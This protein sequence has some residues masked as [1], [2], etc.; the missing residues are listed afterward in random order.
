LTALTSPTGIP[1]AA[2]LVTR[3]F[4]IAIRKKKFFQEK[5][6][7]AIGPL[8]LIALLFTTLIIFAAQGK[9]VRRFLHLFCF[10]SLADRPV[11][12][13]LNRSTLLAP[14]ASLHG[15]KQVVRS[16]TDVLRVVPPL[17]VY[18]LILFFG[19]LYACKRSKVSYGRTATQAFTGA[20]NNF[21]LAIAV[22]VATYGAGASF[23]LSRLLSPHP[24]SIRRF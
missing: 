21:E 12:C 24:S 9:Q 11:P 1:L 8:S 3:G 23:F 10:V 17:L 14:P 4:F 2:A 5:F 7:P 15:R 19:L 20:S 22:A 6:L 16:I 13:L 18:F